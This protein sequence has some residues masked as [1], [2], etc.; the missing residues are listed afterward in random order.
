M[1]DLSLDIS[2]NNATNDDCDTFRSILLAQKILLTLIPVFFLL[3]GIPGNMITIL[4]LNRPTIKDNIFSVYLSSLC[5]F[6][7]ITL[8][9]HSPR[10]ISQAWIQRELY[11][12]ND[13]FCVLY[14]LFS[15]SAVTIATWLLLVITAARLFFITER[16]KRWIQSY[17]YPPFVILGLVVFVT[18][19]EIP[20]VAKWLRFSD[21]NGKT[22]LCHQSSKSNMVFVQ[23]VFQMVIPAVGIIS[24]NLWIVLKHKMKDYGLMENATSARLRQHLVGLLAVSST[25]FIVSALPL[26]IYFPNERRI[27]DLSTP[28]GQVK[29][30]FTY[31]LVAL[32]LYSNNATSFITYCFF[33]RRFRGEFFKIINKY[34]LMVCPNLRL[35][36]PILDTPSDSK[37]LKPSGTETSMTDV[38]LREDISMAPS[39]KMV[40]S[41]EFPEGPRMQAPRESLI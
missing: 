21:D 6:N 39:L 7:I 4:V 24:M 37:R 14:R 36:V 18:V 9:A 19:V 13:H 31:S 10:F 2:I 1:Y 11:F 26:C 30:H 38:G 33:G 27:F 23:I 34:I 17:C 5:Y 32:I 12:T 28:L 15:L 22:V 40:P 3:V 25:H 41:S 8:L 29:A 16:T 20:I 35:T